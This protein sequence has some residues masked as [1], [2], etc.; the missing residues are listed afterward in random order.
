MLW[1][2]SQFVSRISFKVRNFKLVK[3]QLWNMSCPICG[4]STKNTRKARGYVYSIGQKL[5]YRCHHCNASMS[6]GNFLKLVD[7]VIYQ[8]YKL[9]MYKNGDKKDFI[10]YEK[11]EKKIENHPAFLN[12]KSIANM[13]A[14]HPAVMYIKSRNIPK[15]HFSKLFYCPKY[16]TWMREIDPNGYLPE[17]DHP[18]LI[19][20]F[21]NEN[22]IIYRLTARAFGNE[23]PKYLFTVIDDNYPNIYNFHSVDKNKTVY[24]L[25]GQIDSLFLENSVAVGSANYANPALL[26]FRDRVVVPDNEPRNSHVV[27]QIKK[28]VD[29]GNKICLWNEFYGKDINECINN[30][31]SIESIIELIR[32]STVSGF[33]AMLK[34]SKWT[35]C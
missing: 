11:T 12:L 35:K 3:P 29:S 33:Q 23:T 1:V 16:F 18:R 7:P 10:S 9:E 8:E 4:D 6:F 21:Y 28:V 31:H 19:I 13:S 20:P 24:I 27:N 5:N 14:S 22:N 26:E 25:E 30:G 2:E 15:D 17:T 34:F 32:V